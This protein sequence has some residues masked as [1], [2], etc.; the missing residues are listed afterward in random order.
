VKQ[1]PASS[2]TGLRQLATFVVG[3]QEYALDIMRIKEIINPVPITQVP[4]APGFM[5]GVIELRGVILP[6]VDLRKRFELPATPVTRA[7]K[8]VLVTLDDKIVALIVD[9]VSEFLRK[10]PSDIRPTPSLVP[11]QEARFFA[12]VCHHNGRILMLL[13]IDRVLTTQ[14]RISLAGLAGEGAA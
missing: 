9:G 14:E 1:D 3:A 6:V 8:Y 5:E 2:A 4:G 7:S 13:D 12:G 11:G 10:P